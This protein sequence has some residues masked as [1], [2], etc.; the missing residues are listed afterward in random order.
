MQGYSSNRIQWNL[1]E[2]HRNEQPPNTT[3]KPRAA[4]ENIS[5]FSTNPSSTILRVF[6]PMTE[7]AALEFSMLQHA[8]P[9]KAMMWPYAIGRSMLGPADRLFSIFL[10]RF[11]TCK[12]CLSPCRSVSLPRPIK[13]WYDFVSSGD[14]CSALLTVGFPFFSFVSEVVSEICRRVVC[15]PCRAR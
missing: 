3:S 13:R 10:V 12:W 9:K 15:A 11:P 6:R 7:T 2:R 5:V 14:Q 8:S 1:D 4:K